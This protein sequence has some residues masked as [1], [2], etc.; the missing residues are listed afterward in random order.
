M[1][2]I[3]LHC[4]KAVYFSSVFIRAKYA[5][6]APNFAT[7]TPS[8]ISTNS[9]DCLHRETSLWFSEKKTLC[10]SGHNEYQNCFKSDL[11]LLQCFRMTWSGNTQNYY[12][13]TQGFRYE[14]I[15]LPGFHF[16]ANKYK[17]I[18]RKICTYSF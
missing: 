6:K 9:L 15:R 4:M 18:F 14:A 12:R 8:F 13:Y 10:F 16:T 3:F 11:F 2:R 5:Q 7:S 1:P 17:W